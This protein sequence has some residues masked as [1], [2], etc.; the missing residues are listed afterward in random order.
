VR[1][2]SSALRLS[3]GGRSDAQGKWAEKGFGRP[4]SSSSSRHRDIQEVVHDQALGRVA[5]LERHGY[6]DTCMESP[7]L[8]SSGKVRRYTAT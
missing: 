2:R 6:Q 3:T 1:Q 5:R 4:H 7:H 8:Y